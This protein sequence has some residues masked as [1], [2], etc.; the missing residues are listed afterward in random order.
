LT[1]LPGDPAPHFVAATPSSPAFHFHTVGGRYV[2][3][4]FAPSDPARFAAALEEI[5]RVRGVLDDE[6]L[7]LF[8]VLR[9][10]DAIAGAEDD[11]PGVRWFLDADSRV[12]SQFGMLEADGAETAAW[13]LLDP[14]LRV[15]V[16]APLGTREAA[17]LLAALP[18]LVPVDDHAGTRLHAPVLIVPRVFEPGFCK[19]LISVFEADG[20]APSGFMRDVNGKTMLLQ[21]SSHKRRSDVL[22]EDETLRE[23][24]RARL[25]RRLAP[26]IFKTFQFQPTRIERYIISRYDSAELGFFRPHRDN[27]T[28]GTAH[29]KFAV[30]LNLNAEDYDGGELRFPEFGA[31]TYRAPTGGAVVFSCSLLHEATPVTR[32]VRYAFLPFLYDE[33]GAAIRE[34]NIGFLAED[35]PGARMPGVPAKP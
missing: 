33:A 34:A 25:L 6:K 30:T 11:I 31:A 28:K 12:F 20:G 1:L 19:H 29:R 35:V 27:T 8:G 23:A 13:I 2:L 22:I 5:A 7:C 21:D 32:G 15:L 10:P 16:N 4:L 17:D 9:A 26:E 18:L 14:T 3:L 24:A